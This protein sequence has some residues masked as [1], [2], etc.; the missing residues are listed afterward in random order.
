MTNSEIAKMLNL[1][2]D[3]IRNRA[4]S[5][6]IYEPNKFYENEEIK[7][8]M[9]YQRKKRIKGKT[10]LPDYTF[11]IIKAFDVLRPNNTSVE[12]AEYTGINVVQVNRILDHWF[13]GNDLIIKSRIN[14][15]F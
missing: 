6:G 2:T 7:L 4:I 9:Y 13:S 3:A 10:I 11:R 1:T 8:L 12:I 15:I 14:T 5:L